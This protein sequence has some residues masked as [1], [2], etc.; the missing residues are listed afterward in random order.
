[1]F[2]GRRFQFRPVLT[3]FAALG[4][5]VL[6]SLGNWQLERLQWKRDLISRVDARIDAAPIKFEEAIS[7]M[8]AGDELDYTP[9]VVDG[10]YVREHE[11]R[12]FGAIEGTPGVFVFTPLQLDSGSFVY[13]NRG[14]VPQKLAQ[15][16]NIAV[17]EDGRVTVTG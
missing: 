3:L 13:I 16:K 2:A 14:F 6:V 8:N 1:M 10:V 15:G 11:M 7:A 17:A 9:V 4:L 12:V 5:G